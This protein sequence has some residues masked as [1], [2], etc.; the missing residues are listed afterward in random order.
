MNINNVLLAS[1]LF[2]TFLYC[3]TVLGWVPPALW[4][5]FSEGVVSEREEK[6]ALPQADCFVL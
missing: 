5:C 2:L 6:R 3:N 1:G 4:K